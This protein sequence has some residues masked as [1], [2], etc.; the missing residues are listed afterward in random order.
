MNSSTRKKAQTVDGFLEALEHPH[1]AAVQELRGLIL[2]LDSR[3][4]E[5]VK[6]NA[7]SFYLDDNFATLRV[8]PVPILQLVLHNGSKKKVDPRQF[9]V[10]DPQGILKWAAKDRCL[11]TFA[12]L[13]DAR[14]KMDA[15]KP[16][17]VSW[18]PQL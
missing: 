8:H 9:K 6:W 14:S 11:V 12:S 10:P 16:I 3:I 2:S 5:E 17:V 1:K 15:L 18:I 13:D 4:K 7:P